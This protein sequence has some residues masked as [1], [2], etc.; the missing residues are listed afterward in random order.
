MA[1]KGKVELVLTADDAKA[2]Q[3]VGKL[4]E[5]IRASGDQ[6]D[7]VGRKQKTL[8]DDLT[9]GV[10]K[11]VMGFASIGGATKIVLDSLDQVKQR[12]DAINEARGK[13]SEVSRTYGENLRGLFVNEP[14]A[15]KE[16]YSRVDTMLR[17]IAGRRKIGEGGLEKLVVGYSN[18]INAAPLMS[19]KR[20]QEAAEEVGRMLEFSPRENPAGIGIGVAKIMQGNRDTVSGVQALNALRVQQQLGQVNDIASVGAANAKLEGA[21][22]FGGVSL[23]E[24]QGLWAYMT[25]RTGDRGGEETASAIAGMTSKIMTRGEKITD[26]MGGETEVS[27][28]IFD[29]LNQISSVYRS[30]MMT[31]EAVGKML[32]D[33]TRSETAKM[34]TLQLL[35][36]EMPLMQEKYQKPMIAA[37]A[38][39]ESITQRNIEDLVAAIPTE[40]P[41]S[42]R[43]SRESRKESARAGDVESAVETEMRAEFEAELKA[44]RLGEKYVDRS[45]AAYEARKYLGDDEQAARAFG[46][47]VG[48]LGRVPLAGSVLAG[49]ATGEAQAQGYA[50]DLTG[51]RGGNVV[52]LLYKYFTSAM[53]PRRPL[54]E[55]GAR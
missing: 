17:D 27:G 15:S 28:N 13:S 16:D 51:Y 44:R 23:A 47:S 46:S 24:M 29:R 52:D 25:Q 30:G 2:V 53:T 39:R 20:R 48:G 19:E 49:I 45:M 3:A 41:Q 22:A 10:T 32:P 4:L 42:S 21:A 7:H 18:V 12:I 35:S 1:A 54:K 43:R 34:A 36:G 37:Y 31:E 38:T 6:F 50:R 8:F 11:F 26:K 5:G 55:T 9:G 40:T 14:G 33:L